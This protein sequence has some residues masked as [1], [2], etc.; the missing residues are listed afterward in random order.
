MMCSYKSMVT[1]IK[2][3]VVST[4]ECVIDG[5]DPNITRFEFFKISMDKPQLYM[6]GFKHLI[7]FCLF[8][9]NI[10][11]NVGLMIPR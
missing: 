5:V 6:G 10:V 7:K 1:I 3:Y 2:L 4:I 11:F 9:V 8:H